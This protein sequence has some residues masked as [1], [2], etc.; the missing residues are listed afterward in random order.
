MY[1]NAH[2]VISIGAQIVL[3][4][5]EP[6]YYTLLN[7]CTKI[8]YISKLVTVLFYFKVSRITKIRGNKIISSELSML[9]LP[10]R[11]CSAATRVVS[12]DSRCI[13]G[14]CIACLFQ[15]E[16]TPLPTHAVKSLSL[17]HL[18]CCLQLYLLCYSLLNAY[19]TSAIKSLSLWLNP[20]TVT[21]SLERSLIFV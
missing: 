7:K 3:C 8:I 17:A 2:D 15:S 19:L 21:E 9:P 5:K 10:L 12:A 1:T 6:L 4:L 16:N 14:F 20:R 18:L 13:C 11:W